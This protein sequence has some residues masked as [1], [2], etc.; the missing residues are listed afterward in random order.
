MHKYAGDE[1]RASAHKTCKKIIHRE[2]NGDED[3]RDTWLGIGCK[4]INCNYHFWNKCSII[5][6]H[7]RDMETCRTRGGTKIKKQSQNKNPASHCGA[8]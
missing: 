1:M 3:V 7:D 8:G 2:K 5:K 6:V 4:C